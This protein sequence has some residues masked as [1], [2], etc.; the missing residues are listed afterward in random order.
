MNN[1]VDMNNV[2]MIWGELNVFMMK[3][4]YRSKEKCDPLEN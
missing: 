3:C 2:I 4:N 1:G